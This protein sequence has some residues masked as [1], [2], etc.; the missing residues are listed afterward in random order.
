LLVTANEA[1]TAVIISPVEY[2]GGQ[3]I[4]FKGMATDPEEGRLPASSLSWRVEFI[5]NQ[6]PQL[7]IPETPGHRRGSFRV[8]RDG[9]MSVNDLYRI[10]LTVT[11]AG[12]RTNTTSRDIRPQTVQ[13]AVTASHPG[14][15]FLV[16]GQATDTPALI[17]AVV[18]MRRTFAAEAS[19][20]VDGVNYTFQ[21]W[22]PRHKREFDFIVPARMREFELVYVPN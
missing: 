21:R 2:R 12:G 1:P 7:V 14:L 15:R 18:G 11:D 9:E 13:I 20:I 10:H 3:T 19:Q 22:A 6:E 5:H 8:P 16:D 17:D 4:R